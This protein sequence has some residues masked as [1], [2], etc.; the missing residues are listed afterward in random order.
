MGISGSEYI[1]V[2]AL[3]MAMIT[4]ELFKNEVNE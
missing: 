1:P 3:I 4:T 2:V